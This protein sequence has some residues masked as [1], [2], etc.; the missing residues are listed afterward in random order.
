MHCS[1]NRRPHLLWITTRSTVPSVIGTKKTTNLPACSSC[2]S[3]GAAGVLP[4]AAGSHATAICSPLQRK[5]IRQLNSSAGAIWVSRGG[6]LIQRWYTPPTTKLCSIDCAKEILK[7]VAVLFEQVSSFLKKHVK[8]KVTV[9][10]WRPLGTRGPGAQRPVVYV[11]I[12]LWVNTMRAMNTATVLNSA[13]SN[14]KV[15][16]EKHGAGDT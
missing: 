10:I 1:N 9:R 12:R 8:K 2:C 7:D 3:L 4:G 14:A 16:N 11:A 15:N 6:T 5:P 13:K